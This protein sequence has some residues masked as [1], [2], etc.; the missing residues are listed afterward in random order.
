MPEH[1]WQLRF[2]M[3]IAV[4]AGLTMTVASLR[5]ESGSCAI[6]L[7]HLSRLTTF[8]AWSW[9]LIGL[10]FLLTLYI[11][12]HSR[13]NHTHTHTPPPPAWLLHVTWVLY[14]V[15]FAVSLLI[16]VMVTFVLIPKA[17]Q[18]MLSVQTFFSTPALLMHNANVVFMV[19]EGASNR[20]P[21][22]LPH[23]VFA[24]LYGVLYTIFAWGWFLHRGVFYYF[25]LDFAHP[26]AV[27]CQLGL[28]GAMA[29]FFGCGVVLS[30]LVEGGGA[31]PEVLLLVSEMAH[32]YTCA[33]TFMHLQFTHASANITHI[34][35]HLFS[36]HIRTVTHA[37]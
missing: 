17:K 24:V 8:T 14:E 29:V 21:F 19:I 23:L 28:V 16:T 20:L 27:L 9:L 18:R 36:S 3:A 34:Y 15:S 26:W 37:N 6:H 11:T 22:L 25:F 13:D 31:R 30:A 1:S 35:M 5:H 2:D 4:A 32:E 7:R 12:H 33:Y 10:Y